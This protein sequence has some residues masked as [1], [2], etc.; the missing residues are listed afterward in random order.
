MSTPLENTISRMT[1]HELSQL[2]AVAA[3]EFARRLQPAERYAHAARGVID[4]PEQAMRDALDLLTPAERRR[5]A[6]VKHQRQIQTPVKPTTQLLTCSKCLTIWHRP[7]RRG[8]P[9]TTCDE[10][11]A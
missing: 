3:A 10:C 8:R 4:T 2:V 9:P 6:T 7:I 5:L 11:R 1:L